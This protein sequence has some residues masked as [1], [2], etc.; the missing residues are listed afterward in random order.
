MA[1][2]TWSQPVTICPRCCRQNAESSLS[3]LLQEERG[4]H[5]D[6]AGLL[7]ESC[8]CLERTE[9]V[10]EQGGLCN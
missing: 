5:D 10:D 1:V 2:G 4:R 8:S 7:D 9:S 3:K 6:V